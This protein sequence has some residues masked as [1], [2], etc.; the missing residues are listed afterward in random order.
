MPA[1]NNNILKF[2]N[3]KN[4][5]VTP[6]VIYADIEALLRPTN[7]SNLNSRHTVTLQQHE[8][9]SVG[10]YLKCSFNNALSYYA[11]RR[12]AD[13]MDWFTQQLHALSQRIAPIFEHAVPMEMDDL[14]QQNFMQ[15]V[16]CHIC[17]ENFDFVNDIIVRD[18]CHF[19]G[20]FR[21]AAHQQCN[22]E[23]RNYKVVPD[24]FHNLT[25]YDSHF[26]IDKIANGFAGSIKVIPINTE[27]YISI[28][29]SVP[30]A[31]GK[32][33]LKYKFIDS[34]RFMAYSLDEL[35]SKIPSERKT[36]LRD[37]FEHLNED[38]ILL[39]ERKGVLCYDYIDSWENLE[40]T[41]LPPQ[42]AFFSSLTNLPIQNEQYAFAANIWQQFTIQT[43]GEY[44]DLYLKV[45]VLLLAIVFEEFRRRCLHLYKL[46]PANYYTTPGL[47]WDAML[48]CT[49]QKIELLTDIYMLLFIERGKFVF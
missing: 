34:S 44:T 29:K 15:A 21:G 32:G 6:F 22:L 39:L 33:I 41:A 11:A 5:V 25:H 1:E 46:D 20:E 23:Y 43:L 40:E 16:K 7:T 24:V 26:L 19:T 3:Y 35:A 4:Q 36:I 8:P 27:K 48:K 12:G 45:D 9:Y 30:N 14:D 37:E 2:K 42:E 28:I 13:C 18:H 10:Y 47:S 38:Q 17:D 49:K 31:N